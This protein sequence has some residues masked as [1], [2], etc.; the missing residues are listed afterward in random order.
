MKETPFRTFRESKRRK[1]SECSISKA[2][3]PQTPTPQ[4]RPHTTRLE[5]VLGSVQTYTLIQQPHFAHYIRTREK[6]MQL[7]HTTR[8]IIKSPAHRVA[9]LYNTSAPAAATAAF[10]VTSLRML[11][12]AVCC[13]LCIGS[14]CQR[15]QRY[16]QTTNILSTHTCGDVHFKFECTEHFQALCKAHCQPR[17]H[18][19]GTMVNCHCHPL[20]VWTCCIHVGGV[21]TMSAGASRCRRSVKRKRRQ[22]H[23]YYLHEA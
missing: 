11:L 22:E 19:D 20:P 1:S 4:T 2:T 9:R 3:T 18:N 14:V 13:A 10:V 17:C 7:K 15:C 5:C 8:R 21:A 23:I 6:N 12:S 16:T